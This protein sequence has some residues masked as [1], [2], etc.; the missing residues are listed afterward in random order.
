MWHNILIAKADVKYIAL[1]YNGDIII[2]HN[3]LHEYTRN[4]SC[5]EV[6]QCGPMLSVE[7]SSERFIAL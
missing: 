7:G 3:Y 4:G 1:M 6:L 2:T 5:F